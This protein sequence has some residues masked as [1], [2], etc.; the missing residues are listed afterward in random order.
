[1]LASL[2]EDASLSLD[3]IQRI[4][5]SITEGKLKTQDLKLESLESLVLHPLR[6]RQKT[7]RENECSFAFTPSF[8]QFVLQALVDLLADIVNPI[9]IPAEK[10]IV[11]FLQK[12]LQRPRL[13][14]NE[15]PRILKSLALVHP[16]WTLTVYR[17]I[18]R[19]L[20]I[21]YCYDEKRFPRTA[22]LLN[23][24]FGTWTRRMSFCLGPDFFKLE[25]DRAPY[26]FFIASIHHRFPNL[27]SVEI[28]I[29]SFRFEGEDLLNTLQS[30]SKLQDLENLK[31]ECGKSE[32]V[33]PT[34]LRAIQEHSSSFSGVLARFLR[35][36][37][38]CMS[39]WFPSS[40][41]LKFPL[42]F[43]ALTSNREFRTLQLSTPGDVWQSD[44]DSESKYFRRLTWTRQNN[45]DYSMNAF[46]LNTL[47]LSHLPTSFRSLGNVDRR[48]LTTLQ[49]EITGKVA[50]NF[51]SH[52]LEHFESL[53]D[54][55]IISKVPF[56][57]AVLES[58]PS[59]VESLLVAFPRT[60]NFSDI[61]QMLKRHISIGGLPSLKHLRIARL[62]FDNKLYTY[63]RVKTSS[64]IPLT[65]VACRERGIEYSTWF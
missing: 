19:S 4:R 5:Q 10:Y 36:R 2:V 15:V 30:L 45:N 61:D 8:P 31:I 60:M 16:S 23:P 28:I 21:P 39:Y 35:L 63:W 43:A 53:R 59:S 58:M 34:F 18:G 38:L 37:T 52:S 6:I 49:V 14:S 12:D 65:S 51:A 24:M 47:Q 48:S 57:D 25:S 44:Q 17:A 7:L 29:K 56:R 27:R 55:E 33:T 26:Y 41:E 32:N 9:H 20:S 62:Y 22:K 40:Q 13:E 54:V 42:E 46:G 11:G 50:W 3:G 1:M 64:S